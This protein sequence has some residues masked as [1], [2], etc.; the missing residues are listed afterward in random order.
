MNTIASIGKKSLLATI[1]I[2]MILV[3]IGTSV[4][5][6]P[7]SEIEDMEELREYDTCYEENNEWYCYQLSSGALNLTF[8]EDI[9]CTVSEE[10]L[11]RYKETGS[12]YTTIESSESNTINASLKKIVSADEYEEIRREEEIPEGTEI[13][14]VISPEAIDYEKCSE[15]EFNETILG[16]RDIYRFECN[17]RNQEYTANIS[18][19]GADNFIGIHRMNVPEEEPF[20]IPMP[21]LPVLILI[22]LVIGTGIWV[23]YPKIQEKVK[24]RK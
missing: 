19:Y 13:E 3:S 21:S 10:A 23:L 5:G 17:Y 4:E 14:A 24:R 12:C 2:C 8:K 15:P 9:E 6:D 1:A 7:T 11:D 20:T 18:Y 22:I 16:L